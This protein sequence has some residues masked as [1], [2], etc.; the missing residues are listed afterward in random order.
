M[1]AYALAIA[2]A[3]FFAFPI[4]A[5]SQ[6][7][8]VA[9][10]GPYVAPPSEGRSVAQPDDCG[11]LRQACLDEDEGQSQSKCQQFRATCGSN[12]VPRP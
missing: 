5:F 11:Q 3:A 2:A 10:R 7:V 12:W 4:S 6:A 1:R 9:P 8:K